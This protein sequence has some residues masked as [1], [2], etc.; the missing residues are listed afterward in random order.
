MLCDEEG[1]RKKASRK[2][3][4]TAE[5]Y[6]GQYVTPHALENEGVSIGFGAK[7]SIVAGE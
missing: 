2:G 6:R 5:I 1:R 4:E 3:I 7:K